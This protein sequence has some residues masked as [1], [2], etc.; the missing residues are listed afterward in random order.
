MSSSTSNANAYVN[1]SRHKLTDDDNNSVKTIGSSMSS[2]SSIHI[3]KNEKKRQEKKISKLRSKVASTRSLVKSKLLP[4]DL[5]KVEEE[6]TKVHNLNTTLSTFVS[7]PFSESS[8]DSSLKNRTLHLYE[9]VDDENVRCLDVPLARYIR[10]VEE[11]TIQKG[12]ENRGFLS[13]RNGFLPM[14]YPEHSLPDTHILWDELGANLNTMVS[15]LTLRPYIENELPLLSAKQEDLEDRYLFRAA[16]ILGLA[17]HAYWYCGPNEPKE[18]PPSLKEPWDTVNSRLGRKGSYLSGEDVQ[19]YNFSYKDNISVSSGETFD[20]QEGQFQIGN[21][22]MLQSMW[23]NKA[24]IV[25]HLAFCEMA[26][27]AAPLLS[28]MCLAQDAVQRCDDEAM[29]HVLHDIGECIQNIQVAFM[30]IIPDPNADTGIEPLVWA[31]TVAPVGVSFNKGMP[32]PSGLGTPFF[33]CLDVFFSRGLYASTLGKD[34]VGARSFFPETLIGALNSIASTSIHVY[35][36]SSDN[37]ELHTAWSHAIDTY[38]SWNGL[39]GKH[40]QK[41]YNFL[42]L[43]F[44]TGREE[45]LGGFKGGFADRMWDKIMD[46][47]DRS[48]E[49]RLAAKNSTLKLPLASLQKAEGEGNIKSLVYELPH[50]AFDWKPG[51]TVSVW[52]SNSDEI[53]S[54]TLECFNAS[55]DEM[56]PLSEE[57]RKHLKKFLQLGMKRGKKPMQAKLRDILRFASL[58]PL[59]K[60]TFMQ[61][62]RYC[63]D[64]A[65]HINPDSFFDVPELLGYIRF[66][67]GQDA[68]GLDRDGDIPDLLLK[69]DPTMYYNFLKSDNEDPPLAHAVARMLMVMGVK[70][71][72]IFNNPV[73]SLEIF[74]EKVY[75]ILTSL[76]AKRCNVLDMLRPIKQRQYSIANA[77]DEKKMVLKLVVANLTYERYAV[78]KY[79]KSIKTTMDSERAIALASKY[80]NKWKSKALNKRTMI[81]SNSVVR[82]F[83]NDLMGKREKKTMKGVTSNYLTDITNSD[84]MFSIETNVSF[85]APSSSQPI[86]MIAA[87][88]YGNDTVKVQC[89]TCISYFSLRFGYLSIPWLLGTTHC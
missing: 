21:L 8:T 71:I 73:V 81:R 65:Y 27:A 76:A 53:V 43:A 60:E 78:Q 61:F 46:M 37:E 49:E 58:S 55:G 87:G 40:L 25:F 72:P 10:Q 3:L 20:A 44:K 66:I 82:Y 30:K 4:E 35:V 67:R 11:E 85:H 18:L 5:L 17:S 70:D 24:E 83:A 47:L 19:L 63:P 69:D 56:I 89:E 41:T 34:A 6:Y 31:K 36:A 51:D 23:G 86:I 77:K 28:L 29:F 32:S 22:N 2:K 75:P 7:G 54:N 9:S 42:E 39:L 59:P 12:N 50:D 57:W 84:L 88:K 26:K 74:E 33:H 1:V 80:F 52:P 45:T 68:L 64:V 13:F 38:A 15:D 79:F 14:L 48:R 16:L 62:T